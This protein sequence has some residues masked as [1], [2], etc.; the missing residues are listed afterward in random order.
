MLKLS[1]ATL[2]LGC[3]WDT[4]TLQMEKRQF[5]DVQEVLAGRFVR[6][7]RAYYE[8]RIEDRIAKLKKRANDVRLL[9]DLAA[10]YDKTGQSAKAVELMRKSLAENP[11][12]YE[13]LANLGTFLVH[14]GELE[15]GT[16]FIRK[17][18]EINPDAHFGREIIQL[19]VIEYVLRC[20]RD[21]STVLPL[22]GDFASYLASRGL[23]GEEG[24]K[25]A[26]TGL[27]GMMFFGNS[28]H[29]ILAEC[30]GDVLAYPLEFRDPGTP[31]RIRPETSAARR[32]AARAYLKASYNT[33]DMKA[34]AHYRRKAVTVLAIQTRRPNSYKELKV[35]ELEVTFR[36]ERIEGSRFFESIR[37][38][39]ERWIFEGADVDAKFEKKYY[40]DLARQAERVKGADPQR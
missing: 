40:S 10:A 28:E 38:N 32:L 26:V 15:E 31:R 2:V 9:D 33:E 13:T 6:H 14:A 16:K 27:V 29:P 19:H 17:A 30:L 3:I 4:H 39:E 37:E 7:S 8:W 21:G 25:K 24:R 36:E 18:I 1:L 20:R 11:K 5:P 34:R 22:N 35:E 23:K 12:R